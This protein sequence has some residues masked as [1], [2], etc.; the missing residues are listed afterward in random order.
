MLCNESVLQRFVTPNKKG[1]VNIMDIILNSVEARVLGSLIEKE[2][3]TPDYYPLT[4]NALTNACNQK[5]NRDPVMGLDEKAVVRG[6]DGLRE[7]QFVWQVRTAGSR[8]SKYEHNIKNAAAFSTQE[9]GILCVLLLRGPQTVGE[10][11]SRTAR[12]YNFRDLSE[13]E[14]TLQELTDR[15]EGPFVVRLPRQTRR[16]ER[17]YTHLF[18]GEVAVDEEEEAPTETARLEVRAENERI[19]ELEQ[20]VTLLQTE[21]SE[22]KQQFAEFVRQFE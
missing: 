19:T 2:L 17:R 13:V 8:V 18:C 10:L 6:L 16:K 3:T 14:A 11:R 21:M 22:L 12:L 7:K 20:K 1:Q 4:L 5:S 15:K 9:I